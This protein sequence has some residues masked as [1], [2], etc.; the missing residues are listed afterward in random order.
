VRDIRC[1]VLGFYGTEDAIIP[2]AD[3][4]ELR[5]RLVASGQPFDVRLYPGAGHVFMNETRPEM[6]RPAAAA[7][8]WPR[9]ATFFRG[10][11]A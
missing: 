4:D 11:L 3:V 6:Y 2:V 8:A 1:P 10:R 9:L 7:D 5:S